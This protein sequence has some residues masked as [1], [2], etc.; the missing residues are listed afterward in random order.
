MHRKICYGC[1]SLILLLGIGIASIYAYT[2]V[3]VKNE[4]STGVVDISLKEYMVQNDTEK[5]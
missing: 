4:F 5:L 2:E 3:S 1:I